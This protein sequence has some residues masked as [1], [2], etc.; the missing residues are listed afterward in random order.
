MGRR[1]AGPH[2]SARRRA[3]RRGAARRSSATRGVSL[4]GV[5]LYGE[6]RDVAWRVG[7]G[8]GEAERD[9]AEE[10]GAEAERDDGVARRRGCASRCRRATLRTQRQSAKSCALNELRRTAAAAPP[11][12]DNITVRRSRRRLRQIRRRSDLLPLRP[13]WPRLHSDDV[14]LARRCGDIWRGV[15]AGDS[16]RGVERHLPARASNY[17]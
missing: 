13:N 5:A 6:A 12:D 15:R 11:G 1:C 8:Q 10:R 17:L 14:Y 2:G 4:R 3:A 7:V 9:G 16:L